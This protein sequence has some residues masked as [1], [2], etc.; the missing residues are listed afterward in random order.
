MITTFK[1]KLNTTEINEC[2]SGT[3]TQITNYG[4][5]H[6][7]LIDSRSS[8]KVIVGATECG[9]FACIP[10]F[11]VGCHLASFKDIFWN[12]EQLC[13]TLGTIDGITVS[14]ALYTIAD[15]L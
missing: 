4:S 11:G 12:E 6:E 5:H 14:K 13:K 9:N 8:I 7:I 3:I 15:F 10:D 1:C 2:W